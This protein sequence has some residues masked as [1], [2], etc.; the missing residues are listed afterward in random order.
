[1]DIR[2]EKSS[3]HETI[4]DLT[5]TAFAPM[6]HSQGDEGDCINTLRA[7]GDL[8]LSLVAEDAGRVIGHV[9]FSP[10][11]MD[12]KF[13]DWQ[14]LGPV[15]VLPGLQK[16]GIGSALIK[17]G[18]AEIRKNGA[19][20]C[21]LI[22]DPAY[23]VRFGFAGDGRLSYRDLSSEFVQWLAF[24]NEKPSGILTFSPGLE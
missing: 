16:T 3:D 24:G 15:S 14:G 10:V 21:V 4:Y 9:A 1:M 8:A 22:G 23:Y 18:L 5:Q 7:D 11:F 2:L 6:P 19:K 12:G 17:T 13:A 20:G